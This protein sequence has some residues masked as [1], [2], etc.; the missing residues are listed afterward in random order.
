[1]Y[2]KVCS[3]QQTAG[4]RCLLA[5]VAQFYPKKWPGQWWVMLVCVL[6]YG[7]CTVA[8]NL[9]ITRV[10]GE[11]FLF[12]RPRKVRAPR[13]GSAASQKQG[14][15]CAEWLPSLWELERF[16]SSRRALKLH[17]STILC[18]WTACLSLAWALQGRRSSAHKCLPLPPR[19]AP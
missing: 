16:V 1:M 19:H 6:A 8:L 15:A 18:L 4:R 2:F 14:S 10:E 12:T 9:F 11:V 5:L 13:T 3:Q 7:A 17:K